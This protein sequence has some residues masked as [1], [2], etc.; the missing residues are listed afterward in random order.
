MGVPSGLSN[1][2]RLKQPNKP[3]E[4]RE[5]V[6]IR[7]AG[8]SGD[9]MQ[10]TGNQFTNQSAMAGNDIVTLPDFPA[11]IRAPAGTLAGVSGFQLNFSS[12][13][14]FTPGDAPDVLVVMNPAAYAV[15]VDDLVEGG[16]LIADSAAFTKSN[17]RKAGF[18][19][20]PL[21]AEGLTDRYRLFAL[22]ITKMTTE[23]VK[24][25]GLPQKTAVRCKNFF[26]LGLCSWLFN[27]PTEETLK[28]IENK[29]KKPELIEA[30]QR[31]FHAGWN[32]GETTDAFAS[33]YEVAEAEIEPGRYTN[34]T[35]NKALAWGLMAAAAKADKQLFYAS[36]P[37]TPASDILHELADHKDFGV[38][39]FQ[40]EDEIAA[41]GVALGASFCGSI[42]VTGTSGPGVSL[43]GE[44]MGLAVIVEL[45][46]IIINVQRGG[47]S[48]GLPTKPE[49]SDLLQALYGRHG[50]SPMAVIAPSSPTDCF[51]AAFEAVCVAIK[52][53]TPVL[54]LSDGFLANG[55]RPWKTPSFADLPEIPAKFWTET[56][57]F[58]PY[59]R[60]EDTLSRP[61]VVPGTPGLEHRVGGLE[62][63]YDSG[64]ISYGPENHERMIRV[65]ASKIERIADGLEPP[66]V[67]GNPDAETLVVGWG[68]TYG[69]LYAAVNELNGQGTKIAHV[70]LRWLNPLPP[71]LAELFARYKRVI[72]AELNMG[73][74][75]RI[76]RERFLIDAIPVNQTQGR[77]F[78]TGELTATIRE[79]IG[80]SGDAPQRGKSEQVEINA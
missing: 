58:H 27:R 43:K 17:L 75:V 37:I 19:G 6:V 22:P 42:A 54:V 12:E 79:L 34:V 26:A 18:E 15:N 55:S 57:G 65:R 47:P 29:F 20:S 76:L 44:T 5:R 4:A 23:A 67:M 63:D 33:T 66:E 40:A 35:G 56:L 38:I 10:L 14:I 1:G 71:G 77:P 13:Q 68:S 78:K 64:N 2:G 8:D 21:D 24:D 62:K 46:M 51:D 74:L 59:L 9:G 3:V 53:M 25:L 50:E 32:Y 52:Y 48:T 28:W 30:N 80:R 16:I 69:A 60:D 70:H 31:A 7:F 41:A 11:E 72:V 39:T 73:Q 45:P 49:Q 36:Y 61:W